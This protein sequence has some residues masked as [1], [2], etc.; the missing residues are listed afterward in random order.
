MEN[1]E[2]E[3]PIMTDKVEEKRGKKP[4][5]KS[6]WFYRDTFEKDRDI[7]EKMAKDVDFRAFMRDKF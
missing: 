4:R 5:K 1:F 3:S 7:Q 6:R 2:T